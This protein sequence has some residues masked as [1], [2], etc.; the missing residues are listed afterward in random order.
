[1]NI[2]KNYSVMNNNP[3]IILLSVTPRQAAEKHVYVYARINVHAIY[4]TNIVPFSFPFTYHSSLLSHTFSPPTSPLTAR[5]R[6]DQSHRR[7]PDNTLLAKEL[8]LGS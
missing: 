1:M 6:A 3:S 8:G 2:I 5:A 7:W 4:I